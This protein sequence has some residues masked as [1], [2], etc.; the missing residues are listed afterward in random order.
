MQ[1]SFILGSFC[2]IDF[3]L[4]YYFICCVS[5]FVFC[6]L[7]LFCLS[8]F[9]AYQ[10]AVLLFIHLTCIN[11]ENAHWS[12]KQILVQKMMKQTETNIT[13]TSISIKYLKGNCDHSYLNHKTPNVT[14]VQFKFTKKGNLKGQFT[15]KIKNTFFLPYI[16]PYLSIQIVLV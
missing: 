5:S 6:L 3:D 1:S 2:S 7:W 4:S 15:P 8:E 12:L 13:T 10:F 9:C 11:S 16:Q 14:D